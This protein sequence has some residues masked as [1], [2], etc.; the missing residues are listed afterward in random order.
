[1]KFILYIIIG[2]CLNMWVYAE[3][4]SL[5]TKDKESELESI[6]FLISNVQSNIKDA[7]SES[8]LLQQELKENE[9]AAAEALTK[10]NGVENQINKKGALLQKLEKTKMLHQGN[11][12][13]ERKYLVHQI[14]TA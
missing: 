10:L 11:L 14:R 7:E 2:L 12:A 1:M 3:E 4:L 5:E 8:E 9:I 6:R 13:R